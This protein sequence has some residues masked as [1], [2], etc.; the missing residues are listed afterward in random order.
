MIDF[1]LIWPMNF[2][3]LTFSAGA[4]RNCFGAGQGLYR[5]WAR[6]EFCRVRNESSV[7]CWGFAAQV[8]WLIAG[9]ARIGRAP[10]SVV[11]PVPARQPPT[12]LPRSH[13]PI[14]ARLDGGAVPCLV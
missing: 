3:L 9:A 12:L 11:L 14:R 2:Y 1:L 10:K 6:N 7:V 5:F 13:P 4:T 8:K